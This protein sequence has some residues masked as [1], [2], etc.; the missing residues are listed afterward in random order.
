MHEM[1]WSWD[2]LQATPTYV[3]R[4]CWDL[5]Q[6]RRQVEQDRQEKARR[7]AERA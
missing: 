5:I 6:I 3:R 7:E 2:A 1:R 4:Y